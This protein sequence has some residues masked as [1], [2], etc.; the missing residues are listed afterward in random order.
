[1]LPRF[2]QKCKLQSPPGEE[3][4]VKCGAAFKPS[5]RGMSGAAG[6]P[7]PAPSGGPPP[8]PPGPARPDP[9]VSLYVLVGASDEQRGPFDY[10]GLRGL[11]SEGDLTAASLVWGKGM[12]DWVAAGEVDDLRP[13]LGLAER[14]P[15]PPPQRKVAIK[16][17]PPGRPMNRTP[18]AAT[19]RP[20][21]VEDLSQYQDGDETMRMLKSD[22][23]KGIKAAIEAG[24]L[25]LAD[26]DAP[27]PT[28]AR[29]GPPSG[30]AP[31]RARRRLRADDIKG[32][33]CCE[34]FRPVPLADDRP[35]IMLGRSRN[36]DLVLPHESVSRAHA[37][38]RVLGD[39]I[40][41]EDK[42]TYGTVVNGTRVR[43]GTIEVGDVIQIGP[44]L[45]SVRER[46]DR[47]ASQ[48]G[49]EVTRPLRTLSAQ[50]TNEAMSGR[51]ERVSLPEVLQTIE[52]NQKSGTLRVFDDLGVEAKLV[53]Y[54]GAPMFAEKGEDLRGEAVV[55]YMLGLARG[56][57]SF[58]TK[59]EAGEMTMEGVT[60]TG[61]LLDF[62]RQQDEA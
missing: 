17:T 38:I 51:L 59:V 14:R 43:E 42:S 46:P 2:C 18:A 61:I 52:F 35:M 15:P 25:A 39:E 33:L 22:R 57:F 58:Q 50:Q 4:C 26:D 11:R 45:I 7:P 19:P 6:A 54:E 48:M 16:P 29:S 34:P 21:R 62:S 36:S 37:V 40:T 31:R 23:D 28:G 56:Q 20:A 49:E 1:M 55:H 5:G 60:L 32:F 3:G 8:P 9:E 47:T 10:A 30:Q 41:L 44:Y 27:A 53:V 13:L 12:D 24:R